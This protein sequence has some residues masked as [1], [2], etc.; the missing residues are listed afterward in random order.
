VVESTGR[1]GASRLGFWTDGC[2]KRRR[3]GLDCKGG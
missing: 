3:A 2:T 1:M